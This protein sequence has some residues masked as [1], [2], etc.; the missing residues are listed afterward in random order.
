MPDSGH[1]HF[2]VRVFWAQVI[3]FLSHLQH[4]CALCHRPFQSR[5]VA[6]SL[7]RPGLQPASFGDDSALHELCYW[8]NQSLK[9]VPGGFCLSQLHFFSDGF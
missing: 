9:W 6:F 4:K 8:H 5:N 7:A 3:E 1:I 2:H